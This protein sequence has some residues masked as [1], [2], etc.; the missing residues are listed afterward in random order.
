MIIFYAGTPGIKERAKKTVK[1]N[2]LHSYFNYVEE[3]LK[4]RNRA[5]IY[6]L[7]LKK[8]SKNKV[9]LFIDSG[10]FSAWSQGSEIKLKDYIKFIQKNQKEIDVYSNL[11]VIGDPKETWR[12]QMMMEQ[13]GLHPLPVFHYGEDEKWLIKYLGRGHKYI[14]LGGMVPISNQPLIAWLDRLWSEFLTD[15]KGKPIV[16]I[17]GF[18]L[19]SLQLITRYPWYSVDSTS[20]VMTGRMGSI[21]IPKRKGKKWVYDSN[22]MKVAVSNRSSNKSKKDQHIETLSPRNKQLVLDYLQEKGYKLG[23]S[24]FKKESTD[25]ILKDNERWA[26]SKKDKK[27]VREVEII[28]EQGVSNTYQFR[29]EL[30]IIYFLDLENSLPKWPWNFKKKNAIKPLF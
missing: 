29:D 28:I 22:S 15:D 5:T 12:N 27:K 8:M 25:Y 2:R 3:K 23:Y 13:N 24:K 16:R 9:E 4:L 14:S 26:D 1:L 10:A 20:W 17:H 18:G 11:D 7:N 21:F 6:E 30:N 19:T